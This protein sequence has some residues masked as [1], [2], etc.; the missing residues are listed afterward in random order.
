V[1]DL[2]RFA[3]DLVNTIADDEKFMNDKWPIVPS[4][5]KPPGFVSGANRLG[6]V[7]IH[8]TVDMRAV[9]QSLSER[10][11]IHEANDADPT[12]DITSTLL[13]HRSDGEGHCVCGNDEWAS[14]SWSE[15]YA[16]HLASAI[17]AQLGKVTGPTMTSGTR[18]EI[19]QMND[20]ECVYV[21]LSDAN[22]RE[23]LYG[24]IPWVSLLPRHPERKCTAYRSGRPL[25]ATFLTRREEIT[26]QRDPE[27]EKRRKEINEKYACQGRAK[28]VYV[29][30]DGNVSFFCTSHLSAS[31]FEGSREDYDRFET[32]LNRHVLKE[33]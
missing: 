9:V 11:S 5:V 15:A 17:V 20:N 6:C 22:S 24:S 2:R 14:E 30:L 33:F 10:W 7:T 3:E 26:G 21:P 19:R 29:H 27:L 4:G 28:W 25:Y 16:S 13:S 32:W 31:G 18:Q 8:A 1:S 23:D 12:G